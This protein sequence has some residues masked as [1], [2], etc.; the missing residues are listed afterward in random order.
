MKVLHILGELKPSGAET[1]LYAAGPLL[2]DMDMD[3]EILSTGAETGPYAG[4]LANA[5]YVIRHI[6]FKKSPVFFWQVFK[7]LKDNNYDVIHLHTERANFWLGIVALLTGKRCVRTIH[8]TFPFSGFLGWKRKWQRQLL[9]RLGLKHITISQSVHDTEYKYYGL[10]TTII[11][12]WYNSLRFRFTTPQQR[13]QAKADL[14]I[15]ADSFVLLTI[16]NCSPIKN[17]TALINA[18][19]LMMPQ[20]WVYLHV[21]IEKDSIERDLAAEFGISDKIR[22]YGLQT[23]IL[24]F[25]QS[26]DLYVMPSTHEGCPISVMEAMAAGL[27]VLMTNVPG[28]IDFKSIF[29]DLVYCEQ[30]AEAIAAALTE[31]ILTDSEKLRQPCAE[32]SKIAEQR[33]GI[34]RGLTHYLEHYKNAAG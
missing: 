17:H 13:I 9:N 31:I 33:F 4:Q 26:S 11:P 7:L 34:L 21:G 25:L 8:S 12:N 27:P 5:G 22:F 2:K 28:L 14:N 24:P 15:A 1:M 19:A 3:A 29:N 16:G 20:N 18:L 23:D 10:H 6:P 30:N 32:N